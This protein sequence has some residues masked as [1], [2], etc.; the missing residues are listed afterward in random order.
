MSLNESQ[1]L[2]WKQRIESWHNSHLSMLAWCRENQVSY[3]KLKYWRSKLKLGGSRYLRCSALETYPDASQIYLCVN[4]MDMHKSFDHF[5]R[6][7]DESFSEI[8]KNSFFVFLGIRRQALKI[9]SFDFGYETIMYKRL[10]RG[11]FLFD[12]S[13]K[14]S[15]KHGDFYILL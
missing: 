11:T 3:D 13:I 15:A 10:S 8:P 12:S 9:F 1:I 14:S 5:K 6:F 7:I 4:T 2:E